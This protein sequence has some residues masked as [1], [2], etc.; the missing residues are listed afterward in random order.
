MQRHGL[1]GHA[2]LHGVLHEWLERQRRHAEPGVRSV[3][4]DDELARELGL[5]H[6]EVRAGVLE[7][8][9][10][11]D[12]PFLGNGGEILAQVRVEVHRD[13]LGEFGVLVAEVVDARHG[14]VD[15]VG[16]HLQRR[17]AG[18]LP[19]GLL[20]QAFVLL[21]MLQ[22]HD[23]EHGGR[24]DGHAQGDER[25]GRGG[26]LHERGCRERSDERDECAEELPG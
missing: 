13:L 17:Y 15:E 3:E 12:G 22:R 18:A 7:F 14:V 9:F 2:V 26:H 4:I 16:P 8:L 20:L 19:R 6:G 23:G 1:G 25:E 5:F 24:R 21:E 11:G 10:E